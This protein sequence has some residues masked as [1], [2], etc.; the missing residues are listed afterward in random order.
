[1]NLTSVVIPSYNHAPF[2]KQA[3][4]SV[5][6]QSYS[7]VELIV[8]DD[9]ST[10]DSIDYL[11]SV[12]DPR[13]TLIIQANAGAHNAINKGLSLAKG[14]FL[15]ILNSDDIFHIERIA[16]C[17][18]RL[19]EGDIDLV[20][21]WIHIINQK[22]KITGVKE[23]WRN[24]L[25]WPMESFKCNLIGS[26]EFLGNLLMTNFVSTTSNMVFT[27]R[28]FDEIGGMR[29]LRFAHDWDFLLRAAKKFRCDLIGKPL[30]KYRIHESNTITTDRAWMLFEICWIFAVH[31][32]VFAGGA[33]FQSKDVANLVD[34][35]DGLAHSI[36]TQGNDKVVWLLLQYFESCN[37][38]GNACPEETVIENEKLR[39]VFIRQIVE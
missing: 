2:I 20:A 35:I 23:G 29:N 17:V 21:T 18:D 12:S 37:K 36:N 30:L 9:G 39:E 32:K 6:G 5:L 38:L 3:V 34:E 7:N 4:E 31:L 27:R 33:F 26:N 11:R 13:F 10:D 14:D 15:A 8:I 16:T 28:L 19:K 22:G 25:P 24:M 1:M